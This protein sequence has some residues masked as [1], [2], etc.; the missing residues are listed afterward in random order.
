MWVVLRELEEPGP[1]RKGGLGTAKRDTLVP[2]VDL[3]TLY[4]GLPFAVFT[5]RSSMLVEAPYSSLW[6]ARSGSRRISEM[7]ILRQSLESQ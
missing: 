7:T 5:E 6:V 3:G 4:L 1:V 2:E